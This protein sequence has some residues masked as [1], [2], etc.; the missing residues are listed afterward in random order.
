[1]TKKRPATGKRRGQRKD[2]PVKTAPLHARQPG[3]P[4]DPVTRAL[5]A[6]FD[7]THTEGMRALDEH[8]FA[9]VS[10]AI[11]RER[12]LIGEQ[13]KRIANQRAKQA[14]RSK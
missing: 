4:K 13:K 14:T 11:D 10:Q 7:A 9:R 3:T 6:D 2:G 1:M 12:Q 8:D 5:K